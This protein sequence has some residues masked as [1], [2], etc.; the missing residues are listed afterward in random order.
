LAATSP[1]RRSVRITDDDLKISLLKAFTP[2]EAE[3]LADRLYGMM[4]HLRITSLLAEVD[5]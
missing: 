5:R 3:A 2:A 1:R 4:P